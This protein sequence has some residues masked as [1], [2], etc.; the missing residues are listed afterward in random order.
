MTIDD[1]DDDNNNNN[2]NDI[3]IIIIIIIIIP[4]NRNAT[5]VECKNKGDTSNNRSNWNYFEILQ[6]IL[7]QHTESMISRNYRKQLYWAQH[8]YFGKC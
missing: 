5:H 4:Y 2:N 7:E 3:I 6:K 1:D 8:T